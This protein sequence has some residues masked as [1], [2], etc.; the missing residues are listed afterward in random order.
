VLPGQYCGVPMSQDLRPPQVKCGQISQGT[1]LRTSAETSK[2]SP[3]IELHG[4][5]ISV[6]RIGVLPA[7]AGLSILKVEAIHS[8]ETS[9]SLL[10]V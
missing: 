9:C 7:S 1:S 3:L 4:A 10:T 6:R 5:E 8:T 2:D